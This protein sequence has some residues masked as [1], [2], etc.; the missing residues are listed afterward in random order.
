MLDKSAYRSYRH[1]VGFLVLWFACSL[2]AVAKGPLGWCGASSSVL[3]PVEMWEVC[4][5]IRLPRVLL[6]SLCG[7]AL[8]VAGCVMQGLLRNDLASPAVLGLGGAAN[9]MCVA[10]VVGAPSYVELSGVLQLAGFLGCALAFALLWGIARI[11]G[12]DVHHLLLL[13]V[14]CA[15][16]WG[17]LT[18]LLLASVLEQH[19][20]LAR[21]MHWMMGGFTAATWL[22][23]GGCLAPLLL[24][25]GLAWQQA[26]ALDMWAMHGETAQTM[27][28]DLRYLSVS[29]VVAVAL[30]LAVCAAVAG[31]LP[32]VG[33]IV[34]HLMRLLGHRYHADL[35]AFSAV[36]GAT[37]A[38]VADLCGRMLR[39]PVEIEAGVF[40]SLLGGVFFLGL[41]IYSRVGK[42]YY[43]GR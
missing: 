1:F 18:M 31:Q 22:D 42:Q 43:A 5:A 40:T 10:L 29:A 24:G 7:A 3:P 36:L 26:D 19:E 27:G 35:M 32:F 28:V 17:A 13:G 11:C 15:A 33:L 25:L 6:A 41:L 9:L 23:I 14:A 4:M 38:V 16:I 20:L 30:L 21:A 37:L 2:L 39:P 8:A 12:S 34:P